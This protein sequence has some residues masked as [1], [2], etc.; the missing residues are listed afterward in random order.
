MVDYHSKYVEVNSSPDTRSDT[1]IDKLKATF[2]PYNIPKKLLTDNG[3][4][5]MSAVFKQFAKTLGVRTYVLQARRVMLVPIV[6]QNEK[7]K[8]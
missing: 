8:V 3:L 5:F 2:A 7:L 4:Q 6:T 1:A